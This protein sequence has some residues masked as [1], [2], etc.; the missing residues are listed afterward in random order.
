[1]LEEKDEDGDIEVRFLRKAHK[2][3]NAYVDPVV[4]D[5][6]AVPVTSVKV[7]LPRPVDEQCP[8]KRTTR[9]K[10]FPVNLEHYHIKEEEI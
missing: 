3:D 2:I 5:I 4:K 6:H 7:V 9:I 8:T 10:Q 1:M